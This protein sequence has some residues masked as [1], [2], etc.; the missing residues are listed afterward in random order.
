MILAQKKIKSVKLLFFMFKQLWFVLGTIVL[1]YC[2]QK[3]VSLQ[4]A[5]VC[6]LR[7]LDDLI[8]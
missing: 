3:V 7:P 2:P 6:L 1:L 4:H 8:Q 5:R